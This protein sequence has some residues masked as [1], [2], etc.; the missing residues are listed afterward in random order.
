MVQQA[1]ME[2]AAP[3]FAERVRE[4]RSEVADPQ[5]VEK[6]RRRRFGASY[7]LKILE[8]VDRNP[9]RSGAHLRREGLYSSHLGAWSKQRDEEAL[10]ALD[11]ERNSSLLGFLRSVL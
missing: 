7:R 3:V 5:V 1:E 4:L 9:Q 10:K 11:K 6:A 8:A 2:G